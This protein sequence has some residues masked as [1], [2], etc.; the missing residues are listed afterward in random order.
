M[1]A[2]KDQ[3]PSIWSEK[4]RS[5]LTQVPHAAIR[6]LPQSRSSALQICGCANSSLKR[7]RLVWV[8]LDGLIR[9]SDD[10][11]ARQSAGR[12]RRAGPPTDAG[13]YRIG[14]PRPAW[15]PGSCGG[16]RGRRKSRF[17]GLAGPVQK[18]AVY[19]SQ[20]IG[21]CPR[22]SIKK[23]KNRAEIDHETVLICA[24]FRATTLGLLLGIVRSAS[25]ST[26]HRSFSFSAN[27]FPSLFGPL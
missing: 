9:T 16:G 8:P 10:L 26:S 22:S 19:C 12:R 21:E 15:G 25:T 4:R 14:G 6:F 23:K 11:R 13:F 2:E 3:P 27:P 17:S 7:A 1:N 18:Q 24:A 20:L 5:C